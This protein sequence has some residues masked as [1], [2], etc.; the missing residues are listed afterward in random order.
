MLIAG[1]SHFL[2]NACRT[3]LES[4]LLSVLVTL[5]YLKAESHAFNAV[6]KLDDLSGS[7]LE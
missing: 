1:C 2:E 3:D 4:Y 7:Y 5:T 6:V